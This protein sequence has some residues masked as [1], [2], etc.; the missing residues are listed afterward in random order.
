MNV[1]TGIDRANAVPLYHQ[2]FLALRDSIMSGA[3]AFG[4]ILPSEERLAA[5]YAVS[6]ITARRAL[7]ELADHGLVERRRRIGT[8]VVHRAAARPIEANVDQAVESLLAFGRQTQVRVIE[9]ATRA[10][11]TGV[12]ERL[13]I[14]PGAAVI[15]AVRIRLRDGEPLGEV[16]SHVPQALGLV[17]RRRDLIETPMLGLLRAAGH[18][19]G[20][21]AQTISAELAGNELAALLEVEVRSAILRIERTVVDT[22]GRALLLTTARY[23]ADRYRI[24]IDLQMPG[25]PVADLHHPDP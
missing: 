17:L 18:Q 12:A 7:A 14:E 13:A 9:M 1:I 16:V 6:R 25:R 8:R 23:R 2:I 21:G 10:A 20:G 22:A 24:G 4:A 3:H 15:T 5:D 11:D 19:I